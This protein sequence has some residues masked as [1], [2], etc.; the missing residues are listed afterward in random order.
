MI[1][2]NNI[3]EKENVF[4]AVRKNGEHI[5]IDITSIRGAL[6]YTQKTAARDDEEISAWAKDNPVVGY[7]SCHLV[8][9]EVFPK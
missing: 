3:Q 7:A 1:K 9:D 6:D 8:I 4:A 5:Y 2:I